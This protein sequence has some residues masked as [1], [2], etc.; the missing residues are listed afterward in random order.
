MVDLLCCVRD[1]L[2][3]ELGDDVVA[4]AQSLGGDLHAEITHR[5]GTVVIWDGLLVVVEGGAFYRGAH[6]SPVLD[7]EEVLAPL[8]GTSLALVA[9]ADVVFHWNVVKRIVAFLENCVF[10]GSFIVSF[11]VFT[12]S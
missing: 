8:I 12:K 6:P 2:E 3:C 9:A 4:L 10:L 7:V 1:Q 11:D 5:V